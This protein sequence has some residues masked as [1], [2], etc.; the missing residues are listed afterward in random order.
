MWVSI[1][2][3]GQYNTWSFSISEMVKWQSGYCA[4]CKKG[5]GSKSVGP[6]GHR[7]DFQGE[8]RIWIQHLLGAARGKTEYRMG[9]RITRGRY[10]TRLDKA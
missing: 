4:H 5:N 7:H 6:V 3:E 10:R 8:G 1:V 9:V 2:G